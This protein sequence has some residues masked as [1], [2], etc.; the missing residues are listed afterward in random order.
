VPLEKQRKKLADQKAKFVNDIKD[1]CAKFSPLQLRDPAGII[2]G[3]FYFGF[4]EPP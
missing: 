1:A 3:N 4:E 2:V